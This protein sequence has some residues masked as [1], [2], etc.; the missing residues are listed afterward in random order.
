MLFTP[1]YTSLI[2]ALDSFTMV[3]LVRVEGDVAHLVPEHEGA[4]REEVGV[5]CHGV[6]PLHPVSHA[7]VTEGAPGN[8][9]CVITQQ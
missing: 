4:E 9:H 3:V 8:V 6:I 7:V 5:L 2:L 1:P